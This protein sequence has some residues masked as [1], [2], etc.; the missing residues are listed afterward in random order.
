MH[1]H[2]LRENTTTIFLI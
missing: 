2:L 1:D